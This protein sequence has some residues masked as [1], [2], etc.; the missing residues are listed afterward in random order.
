MPGSW[1]LTTGEHLIMTMAHDPPNPS[2]LRDRS[3]QVTD[4]GLVARLNS[5]STSETRYTPTF[6]K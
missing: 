3:R 1:G 6:G 5:S 2:T 4:A